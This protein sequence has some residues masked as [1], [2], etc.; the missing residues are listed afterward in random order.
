[1]AEPGRC[2][3]LLARREVRRAGH[4]RPLLGG[5]EVPR[6]CVPGDDQGVSRTP[7]LAA[8]HPALRGLRTAKARRV[9]PEPE[10]AVRDPALSLQVPPRLGIIL[11]DGV[12]RPPPRALILTCM[13][14]LAVSSRR[15]APEGWV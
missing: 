5:R 4:R 14:R 2:L 7:P 15:V 13:K 8:G 6:R 12:R 9:H 3:R 1:A 11:G 10:P